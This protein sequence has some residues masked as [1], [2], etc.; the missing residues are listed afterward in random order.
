M[1]A[2]E[3]GHSCCHDGASPLK[4]PAE[5]TPD[6]IGKFVCPMCPDVL[7]DTPVPCPHCGMALERVRPVTIGQG[8]Q[9][10][11]P[12]HPEVVQEGPGSC[13]KCGMALEPRLVSLEEEANPELEDMWRRF[14]WS[15]LLTV[16]VAL[17]T[18][19]SRKSVAM[20]AAMNTAAGTGSGAVR[21]RSQRGL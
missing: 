20:A 1:S 6:R 7:E 19:P 9:Y 14:R 21:H 5:A 18:M 2:T 16:P 3:S 15:A 8:L 12:M 4:A 11:C 17:A 13:P 10:T